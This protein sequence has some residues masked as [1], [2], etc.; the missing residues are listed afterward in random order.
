MKQISAKTFMLLLAML[1][2][3]VVCYSTVWTPSVRADT[4]WWQDEP[5]QP[6]DPNQPADPNAPA[7]PVPEMTL[8]T[9]SLLWLSVMPADVNEPNQ[10]PQPA[11]PEKV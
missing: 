4:P 1:A 11:P 2:F 6:K 10:P 9:G 8:S 3:A 7:S 5:N